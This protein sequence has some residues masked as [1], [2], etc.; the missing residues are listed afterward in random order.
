M[1][2]KIKISLTIVGLA[3]LAVAAGGLAVSYFL[4]VR[5]EDQGVDEQAGVEPITSEEVKP[6]YLTTMTHLEENWAAAAT[7][8]DYFNRVAEEIRLGMDWAEAYDAILTFETGLPFAQGCLKFNNNVMTEALERGHGVGVH[9]DLEAKKELPLNLATTH[10]K[11]RINALRELVDTDVV[12][13]SGVNGKSD[14]YAASQRA[15]CDYV[16]GIVAFAYLSMPLSARPDGYTDE[17]ILSGL[18]HQPA[19]FGDDRFYPI[20]I[21]SSDD[22]IPDEDGDLLLSSGETFSLAMYAEA[23]DR[24][25][26]M[27]SCGNECSLTMDDVE[28]F[29]EEITDFAESRDTSKIAKF[30]VYFPANLFVSENEKVLEAFF[31]AAQDLQERGIVE[32][33]SQAGVYEAM[34]A[35]R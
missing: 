25:G 32:W 35:E 7:N 22:F 24:N 29:V 26:E 31:K 18:Y 17:A 28:T 2:P 30:N 21:D 16:D 34:V 3:L 20:W 5:G 6:L 9:P 1:T 27:P 10:I 8:R 15:G 11:E 14:W 33:S 19:P 12:G 23:G 13:C 4:S